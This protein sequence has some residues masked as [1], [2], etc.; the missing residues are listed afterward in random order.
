MLIVLLLALA[1]A[2]LFAVA[3]AVE[4]R[5]A[6]RANASRRHSVALLAALRAPLWWAGVGADVAGFA[7]YA[8]ALHIGPLG[9]VQP[10]M[11][12][13]LLFTLPL[14]ALG[15]PVHP[16]RRDWG[17]A[18]AVAVG[19]ILVLHAAPA[20]AN[21]TD[22]HTARLALAV[23]VASLGAAVLTVAARH[24]RSA[25]RA[26]LLSLAAAG[27]VA[28]LAG[29]AKTVTDT[30]SVVGPV[31]VLTAWP[32]YALAVVAV[33]EL[34][35]EQQA[36]IAGPLTAAQTT[37]TVATPVL[38]AMLGMLVFGERFSTTASGL[39]AAA[40][41]AVLA[42]GGVLVLAHSPL[43]TA[44]AMPRTPNRA[45]TGP[46]SLLPLTSSKTL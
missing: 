1:S 15:T 13:M 7:A 19:L 5:G 37:L 14:A 35:Y 45:P 11:V 9:Q 10:L 41:G 22:P 3:S 46:Q 12:T 42:G 31:A 17:A 36:F 28:T 8:G 34:A 27:L 23:L 2:A 40:A 44:A 24:R 30:L 25:V 39:G 6:L 32:V 16:R 21:S 18:A 4:Q 33:A 26:S 43:L 20:A 38:G 29:L